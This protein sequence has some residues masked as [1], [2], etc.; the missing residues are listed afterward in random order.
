MLKSYLPAQF[1]TWSAVV[2]ILV[3]L[4]GFYKLLFII[5][6]LYLILYVILRKSRND[7]RDDPIITKG[8]IFS[9][10]NGKILHIEKNVSHLVYGEGYTEIQIMIPWWKEMG[11]YLPL[12]SEIVNL[13]VHK[14]RS[15]F[16]YFKVHESVSSEMGKGFSLVLDNRGE[17]IGMTFYK[18]R[19]GLYPEVLVMP[20]D[21]GGRRVNIGYFP[22]GGTLMLY[23]PG[24]Y[25]I[26]SKNN[27]EISAGETIMAVLSE[28]KIR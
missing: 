18:C 16:R 28:N 4:L 7:F 6:V 1:N 21:R 5:G 3:W 27:D 19:L 9:P 8:V 15:F 12:S 14:G 17:F 10:C 13:I 22:F 11:I 20:G 2:A 24:K 25:E 26:L 23:L